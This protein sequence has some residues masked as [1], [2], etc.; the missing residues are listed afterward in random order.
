MAMRSFALTSLTPRGLWTLTALVCAS[1]AATVALWPRTPL[2]GPRSVS[3]QE[4]PWSVPTPLRVDSTQALGLINGR[5]L[6]ALAAPGTPGAAPA[7]ADEPPLTPPDW[8][9]VATI[10][11]GAQRQVLVSTALDMPLPAGAAPGQAL[12][13]LPPKALGVGDTLPGGARILEIRPNGV[14][15]SLKGRQVFLSTVPQ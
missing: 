10:I 2:P 13:P 8:R 5:P 11:N 12:P 7:S 4:A 3:A 1:G 9:I 14:C 6:W 15:L